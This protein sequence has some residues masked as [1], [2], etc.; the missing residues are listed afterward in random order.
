M[1]LSA[2]RSRTH[3]VLGR[4]TS[5]YPII[6]ADN[7]EN[8]PHMPMPTLRLTSWRMRAG[9]HAACDMYVLRAAKMKHASM[10]AMN[11]AVWNE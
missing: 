11:V 9:I 10:F 1:K 7:V 3:D 2:C 4:A 5:S 8:L 6:I